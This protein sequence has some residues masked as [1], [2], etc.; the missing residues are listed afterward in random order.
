MTKRTKYIIALAA[1]VPLLVDACASADSP[2][3]PNYEY[4]PTDPASG[5]EI[6]I[7]ATGPAAGAKP[8]SRDAIV[9]NS[10]MQRLVVRTFFDVN[11]TPAFT[12]AMAKSAPNVDYPD[13]NTYSWVREYTTDD[14]SKKYYW[15]LSD[16][17]NVAYY[18]KPLHFFGIV[19]DCG[20]YPVMDE[21]TKD[22]YVDWGE[23]SVG[24]D[25]CVWDLLYA[26]VRDQKYNA[27]NSGVPG[28]VNLDFIHALCA[29][30]IYLRNNTTDYTISVQ[31]VVF[32]NVVNNARFTYPPGNSSYPDNIG[33]WS[34]QQYGIM[35]I[36]ANRNAD[37]TS[38]VDIA[39]S[40]TT[41]IVGP[42]LYS[43]PENY[44]FLFPQTLQP[45]DN[46]P[47]TSGGTKPYMVLDVRVTDRNGNVIEDPF[48]GGYYRKW[49]AAANTWSD[50]PATP[51][52]Y[53]L[54][55][56]V[57]PAGHDAV[58]LKQNHKYTV[59]INFNGLG[60]TNLTVEA[61]VESYTEGEPQDIPINPV[62]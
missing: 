62:N 50:E 19:N 46:V 17:N 45:W 2:G 60:G 47:E 44:I 55:V 35:S 27:T 13:Y 5:H 18:Y 14:F 61:M 31:T 52:Y 59:N 56:P 9:E 48:N 16:D 33:T 41:C 29:M 6:V 39:P 24:H 4:N 36:G 32:H 28:R 8:V 42:G 53:L 37:G 49:D 15:P 23:T 12:S 22:V 21:N 30:Q 34:N 58:E 11:T 38:M 43:N 54:L 51:G 3:V 25:A 57:V 1:T 10:N 40:A 20:H 7:G 26:C